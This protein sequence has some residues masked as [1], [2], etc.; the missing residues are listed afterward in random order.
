MSPPGPSEAS[1][2]GVERSSFQGSL[3]LYIFSCFVC[4]AP[5]LGSC[6][7]NLSLF[8]PESQDSTHPPSGGHTSHTTDS[9]MAVLIAH[10]ETLVQATKG[11]RYIACELSR[12]VTCVTWIREPEEHGIPVEKSLSSGFT[13]VRADLVTQISPDLLHFS[14]LS[15]IHTGLDVQMA[16]SSSHH[17]PGMAV[18]SSDWTKPQSWKL[19]TSVSKVVSQ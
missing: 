11:L 3:G 16:V 4:S 5:N 14:H 13:A 7:A 12:L 8:P 10:S 19:K 17:G 2:L 15:M 18:I 1:V 9:D 6:R